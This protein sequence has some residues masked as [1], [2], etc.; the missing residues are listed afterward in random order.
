MTNFDREIQREVSTRLQKKLWVVTASMSVDKEKLLEHLEEHYAFVLAQEKKGALFAAGP[1]LTDDGDN[2][3]N[4][5]LIFRASSKEDVINTLEQD[6]FY[7]HQLR[8][9]TIKAWQVNVGQCQVSVQFSD[10]SGDII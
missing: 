1:F 5:M 4:G 2:S 7:R 3:G 10:Q 9:Y 6:P 8:E